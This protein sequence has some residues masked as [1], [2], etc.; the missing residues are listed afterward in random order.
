M[1]EMVPVIASPP[2]E[3]IAPSR[4]VSKVVPQVGQPAPRAMRPATIPALPRLFAFCFFFLFQSR[5][6]KPMRIPCKMLIRKIGSQSRNGWPTPKMPRKFSPRIWRDFGN[7]IANIR[8]NLEVPPASKFI[9]RPKKRNVGIKPHQKRFSL[10]ASNIP[11]PA[12]AKLSSHF[13]QFIM[14]IITQFLIGFWVIF[15]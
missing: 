4:G 11:L 2:V 5:A 9:R 15:G 6:I 8:S 7:P 10:V 14:V 1:V 12:K 13:L 3:K